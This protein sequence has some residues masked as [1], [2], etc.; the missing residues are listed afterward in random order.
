VPWEGAKAGFAADIEVS[1]PGEWKI[2]LVRQNGAFD[3]R[4]AMAQ[5]ADRLRELGQE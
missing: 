2:T 5:V 3:A 1:G 4:R